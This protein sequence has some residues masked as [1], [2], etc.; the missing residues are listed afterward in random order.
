[1]EA[2][3]AFLC[4]VRYEGRD[5]AA[6]VVAVAVAVVVMV[7]V[8]GVPF[9]VYLMLPSVWWLLAA[10]LMDL[11]YTLSYGSVQLVDVLLRE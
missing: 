3:T 4:W 9:Q 10:Y 6:V 5:E 11:Y 7:V 1:M 2:K 8:E